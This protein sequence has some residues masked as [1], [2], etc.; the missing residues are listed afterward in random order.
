ML[1]SCL[2]IETFVA[3]A[4][5]APN[6]HTIKWLDTADPAPL[7]NIYVEDT[8][9][10][11]R[12]WLDMACSQVVLGASKVGACTIKGT[13]I[14]GGQVYAI[15]LAAVP[16]YEV[17]PPYLYGQDAVLSI[18]PAGAPVA[19]VPRVRSLE[20]TF[21]H[22]TEEVRQPGVGLYPAFLR[23]GLPT[24][25]LNVTIDANE[26]ND[27]QG[28]MEA[29]TPL[30]I[31]VVITSIGTTLTL[32]WPR[33]ILPKSDLGEQ[34]KYVAYTL[35]LDEKAL[36]KPAGGEVFTATLTNAVAEYLQPIAA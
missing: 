28:W 8:A 1:A 35:A 27:V 15:A 24:M 23:F 18:G 17:S 34:D 5:D 25:K 22:A 33:V 30:E 29:Q 9:G 12:K 36:L 32:D 14:G 4:D 2:G 10:L 13:Y 11:K 21:D 20:A 16:A 7:S 19:A 26:T 31:K 3:G 6:T